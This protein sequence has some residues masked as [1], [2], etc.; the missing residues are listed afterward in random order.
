MVDN[1]LTNQPGVTFGTFS[2]D[3]LDSSRPG[4]SGRKLLG[5]AKWTRQEVLFQYIQKRW[6]TPLVLTRHF[7]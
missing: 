1:S 2:L 3:I 7:L 5:F 4:L 6:L